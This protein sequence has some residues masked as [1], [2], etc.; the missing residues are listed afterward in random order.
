VHQLRKENVIILEEIKRLR[1]EVTSRTNELNDALKQVAD[2]QAR[3][4]QA[5]DNTVGCNRKI[6]ALNLSS[7][8]TNVSLE[9]LRQGVVAARD[10]FTKKIEV[11]Q[12]ND[13]K[14]DVTIKALREDIV[15]LR[16]Q[17]ENADN[18]TG[19]VIDRINHDLS[20]KAEQQAVSELEDRMD[21]ILQRLESRLE[22]HKSVS[23][24][25]DTAE[26]LMGQDPGRMHHRVA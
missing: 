11:Q 8:L 10:D 24:V 9:V 19:V 26:E 1:S 20:T 13:Q 23:R 6:E 14:A 25:S 5:A 7:E 2:L 15:Q 3:L 4:K 18:R 12:M 17:I 21:Q 22:T 16:K